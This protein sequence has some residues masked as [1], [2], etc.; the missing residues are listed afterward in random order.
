M[1]S[2]TVDPV[3]LLLL[4]KKF[5]TVAVSIVPD[6]YLLAVVVSSESPAVKVANE[7]VNYIKQKFA[8]ELK[9]TGSN[10]RTKYYEKN[11]DLIVKKQ[12]DR[13]KKIKDMNNIIM[14]KKNEINIIDLS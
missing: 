1:V 7:L 10:Y 9:N 11:R 6:V 8:D 4:V 14:N 5:V 13:R 3:P 2:F 12:K